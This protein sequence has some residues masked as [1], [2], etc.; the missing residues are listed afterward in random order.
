[1][2]FTTNGNMHRHM[3]IHEK[4]G[5]FSEEGFLKD[6]VVY[7]PR[8]KKKKLTPSRPSNEKFPQNSDEASEPKRRRLFLNEMDQ[9]GNNSMPS[10]PELYRATTTLFQRQVLNIPTVRVSLESYWRFQSGNH[11]LF[12][13]RVIG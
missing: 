13:V 4:C 1:M 7:K 10:R 12:F 8:G 2:A 9:F 3:R 5:M 11:G 6:G